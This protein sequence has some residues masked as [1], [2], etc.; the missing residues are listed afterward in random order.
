MSEFSWILP[1]GSWDFLQKWIFRD[2]LIKEY[3]LCRPISDVFEH[4]PSGIFYTARQVCPKIG[5]WRHDYLF[6]HLCLYF[7][8]CRS[9]PICCLFCSGILNYFPL[10]KNVTMQWRFWKLNHFRGVLI[11]CFS[12]WFMDRE[13]S[14]SMKP[15]LNLSRRR[16]HIPAWLHV[17]RLHSSVSLTY[18]FPDSGFKFFVGGTELSGQSFALERFPKKALASFRFCW[19]FMPF[20]VQKRSDPNS[21][22]STFKNF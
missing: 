15:F 7:I 20:F 18:F 2:G 12:L 5:F 21:T 4:A 1:L 6:L 19:G 9:Q 22:E 3:P 16:L 13:R 14:V 10:R 17:S 11:H 8:A